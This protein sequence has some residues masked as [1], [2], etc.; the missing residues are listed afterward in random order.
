MPPTPGRDAVRVTPRLLDGPD[1]PVPIVFFDGVCN[2]C[3]R[4][5][6]FLLRRD[7]RGRLRFASLQGTSAR[8]AL[9]ELDASGD[10][11]SI[12]LLDEGG[13]HRRSRAVL[14][15]L[16][17]LGGPWRLVAGAY[18]IPAPILD[19]AYDWVA[20]HRFRWFGR[21]QTCRVPSDAERP[22]LLD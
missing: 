17:G 2:L 19:R 15:T 13:V 6:D 22:R 16:I 21:R 3:N 10:Y 14:R 7:R 20:R 1:P 9:P 18:L 8:A 4:Y 5:V 11:P 12:I